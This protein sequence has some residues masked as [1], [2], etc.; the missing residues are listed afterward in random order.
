MPRDRRFEYEDDDRDRPPASR[1]GGAVVLL[2]A[3]IVIAL[4]IVAGLGA[5]A[6]FVLRPVPSDPAPV[7]EAVAEPNP[8]GLNIQIA[9]PEPPR[10]PGPPVVAVPTAG[11][12]V[13]QL[14]FGGDEYGATGLVSYPERGVGYQIDVVQTVNGKAR[15]R[16]LTEAASING[17]TVSP[18]GE[19]LAVV[20]SAP[21]DGD[22]VVLYDVLNGFMAG[23]FTPYGKHRGPGVHVPDLVWTQFIGPDRLLTITDASGFDVWSVPPLER[24]VGQPPRGPH[25]LPRVAADG[26]TKSP[27]NFAVTRDGTT[28]VLFNGTGFT[29]YNTRTGAATGKTEPFMKEGG[30]ANFHGAA[31]R[32][33]GTRFVCHYSSYG[34]KDET[35]IVVWEVPSGRQLL[36]VQ[37]ANRSSPAGMA[38]WGPDHLVYWHGGLADADIVEVATGDVVGKVQFKDVGKMGTVPPTDGLWGLTPSSRIAREN[39][40]PM[41]V[42]GVAIPKFRPGAKLVIR[43]DGRIED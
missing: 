11:R 23:R 3:G 32:A 2:V 43:P 40:D 29:F 35:P 38:W 14:V 31:V 27:T 4:V 42:R 18:N 25:A 16:V 10:V 1:G 17:V 9:K 8:G 13:N 21:S 20:E 41:L 37:P 34:Q 39:V 15:G 24:V 7:A 19:W 30:S 33:D 12:S 22:R 6:I 28:L 36:K 26:F 5:A